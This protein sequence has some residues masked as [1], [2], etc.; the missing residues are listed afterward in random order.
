MQLGCRTRVAQKEGGK[1]KTF[2]A[3]GT[4]V[5]YWSLSG[6]QQWPSS[7]PDRP[8]SP[9]IAS[10]SSLSTSAGDFVDLFLHTQV[11]LHL[12]LYLQSPESRSSD[13]LRSTPRPRKHCASMR[14]PAPLWERGILSGFLGVSARLLFLGVFPGFVRS[15][16]VLMLAFRSALAA[17]AVSL[18]LALTQNSMLQR[19]SFSLTH[20]LASAHSLVI[21][22]GKLSVG[23]DVLLRDGDADVDA[24][25]FSLLLSLPLCLSS[26]RPLFLSSPPPFFLSSSRSS[27][28][29]LPFA[30]LSSFHRPFPSLPLPPSQYDRIT[31]S[32]RS[33][34]PCS[35]PPSSL[36]P[37]SR[38]P[39]SLPSSSRPSSSSY[40]TSRLPP[41][42]ASSLR[43]D[44]PP[45]PG[46]SPLSC[47][48]PIGY[49]PR[50]RVSQS[51]IELNLSEIS[52][53]V[54][55]LWTTAAR[56]CTAM[57]LT[58]I[59]AKLSQKS[60][61]DIRYD[62]IRTRSRTAKSSVFGSN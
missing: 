5:A 45:N 54:P 24:R 25:L 36:P 47:D 44:P 61:T 46:T 12:F 56:A 1:T 31:L 10:I 13:H 62:G 3:N 48:P 27:S 8:A 49:S 41:S 14:I 28:S 35:R 37:F 7:P 18:S 34:P 38:P 9:S 6:A 2:Y 59:R 51:E 23:P 50:F 16:C 40:Y 52:I 60:P 17:P 19:L 39:S 32:H 20:T 26:S 55:L 29:S 15:R 33:P 57:F 42:S 11:C 43:F 21:G 58:R 4:D 53:T 30:F 22:S